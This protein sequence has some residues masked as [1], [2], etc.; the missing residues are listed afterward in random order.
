MMLLTVVLLLLA[1]IAVGITYVAHLQ[2]RLLEAQDTL[3]NH[4]I[5]LVR[6]EVNSSVLATD[7][8][9]SELLALRK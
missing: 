8:E 2:R 6:V 1:V 9:L 3:I 5:E 4:F 7:N